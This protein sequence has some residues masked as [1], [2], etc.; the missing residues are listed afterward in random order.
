MKV[1]ISSSGST[2][3]AGIDPRFGRAANFIIYDT[4]TKDYKVVENSQ[5][6]HARQGA[7]IQAGQTV[8]S[9][10]AKA[11]LTGNCGP[12]AFSVLAQAGIQ[13]YVK[14]TGTVQEAIDSLVA[15]DLESTDSANVEG[16]WM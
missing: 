8:A 11:V 15:G 2:L 6:L 4:D 16:H 13:V 9:S 12:K 3:D 14:V 5:N 7:G 1:A 10:G